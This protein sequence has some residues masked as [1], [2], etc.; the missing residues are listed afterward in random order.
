MILGNSRHPTV[1]MCARWRKETNE[2]M[3]SVFTLLGQVKDIFQLRLNYLL[4]CSS[5][6]GKTTIKRSHLVHNLNDL[7]TEHHGQ[8]RRE[9]S[10]FHPRDSMQ[11]LQ[12]SS[13][14][15]SVCSCITKREWTSDIRG[16]RCST[17]PS[18]NVTGTTASTHW[19]TSPTSVWRT[20]PVVKLPTTEDL[21]RKSSHFHTLTL[22]KMS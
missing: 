9:W 3:C 20:R 4:A 16:L 10:C 22:Q 6:T 8:D 21:I 17:C 12:S 14:W 7:K 18:V 5:G 1:I 15:H 13:W 11:H 19:D 2:T